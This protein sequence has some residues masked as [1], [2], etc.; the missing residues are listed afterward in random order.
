MDVTT[1]CRW[2]W[3]FRN[4]VTYWECHSHEVAC[5]RAVGSFSFSYYSFSYYSQYEIGIR[6]MY[7]SG[8]IR[9]DLVEWIRPLSKGFPCEKDCHVLHLPLACPS[10]W[11]TSKRTRIFISW[12]C[13]ASTWWGKVLVR[14]PRE[15][16]VYFSGVYNK[17]VWTTLLVWDV[18]PQVLIERDV[19]KISEVGAISAEILWPTVKFSSKIYGH[20]LK[21][22]LTLKMN[23][24][25]HQ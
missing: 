10:A 2:N 13:L 23:R 19:W 24:E 25:W 12:E 9:H 6:Y 15:I 20:F 14:H 17:S 21:K 5:F 8:S 11:R 18:L 16:G 7:S 22:V 3:E 1:T 4:H